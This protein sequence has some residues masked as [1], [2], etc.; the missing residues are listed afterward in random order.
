MN[1]TKMAL[2]ALKKVHK[3]NKIAE[4]SFEDYGMSRR[5]ALD[6]RAKKLRPAPP[7]PFKKKKKRGEDIKPEFAKAKPFSELS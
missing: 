5:N 3:V 2:Q 1:H 6:E 7:P 4:R